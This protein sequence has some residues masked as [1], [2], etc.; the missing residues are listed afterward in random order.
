M[1]KMTVLSWTK[2]IEEQA[3][4]WHG[5][6][7]MGFIA[8]IPLW[9]ILDYLLIIKYLPEF[10]VLR[11]LCCLSAIVL[12]ATQKKFSL[13]SKITGYGISF[14]IYAGMGSILPLTGSAHE[15][16][17]LAFMAAYIGSA[18]FLFW[19]VTHSVINYMI[20]VI[21]YFSFSYLL[22]EKNLGQTFTNGGLMI[23]TISVFNVLIIAA[24]V[25]F[26]KREF[27]TRK[28]LFT[29]RKELEMQT[30]QYK[31]MLDSMKVKEESIQEEL[32]I[33]SEI[34]KG[35]LPELPLETG[36]YRAD[37]FYQPLG[38]VGGDL[39][40]IIPDKNGGLSVLIVDVSGH[41]I[42]A[43]LLTIMAKIAFREAVQSNLNPVQILQHI[44]QVAQQSIR[45]IEYMTAQCW[46]LPHNSNTAIFANGAH[47]PALHYSARTSKA[48]ELESRGLILG[49]FTN[50]DFKGSESELELLPGDRLCLLTDGFEETKNTNE[51][52]YG[53]NRIINSFQDNYNTSLKIQKNMMIRD[54]NRYSQ[55]V[56]LQDDCCLLL[57]EKKT[58]SL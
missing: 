16:Y 56:P 52:A 24:R 50:K 10:I 9:A 46:F 57:I 30:M 48:S 8:I 51:D 11:I 26:A 40:D 55:N 49:Q 53:I 31:K 27:L 12:I 41:G 54:W 3:N 33:A 20:G 42:P 21:L 47:R 37:G 45:T 14:I 19:E 7:I 5:L 39:Y 22:G 38:R 29:T 43:A 25:T 4:G 44:N 34:Q 17:N 15:A 1:T 23:I 2:E 35:I 28:Q 58:Q 36:F 6:L 13:S 32:D 18:L